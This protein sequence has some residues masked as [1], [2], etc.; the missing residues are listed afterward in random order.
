MLRACL[1]PFW[2]LVGC[3]QASVPISDGIAFE[4][5]EMSRP[6]GTLVQATSATA[7]PDGTGRAVDVRLSRPASNAPALEITAPRSTWDLKAQSAHF[8]GGVVVVRAGVE[9]RCAVLDVTY[10]SVDRLER[11]VASGSVEVRSGARRASGAT[12]VLTTATGEIVLTGSPTLTEGANT[13]S[14]STI[15]FLLDDE[16]VECQD[17]RLVVAG[18]AVAP[19]PK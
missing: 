19:I 5:V 17:C 2:V 16:R 6:D 9:L 7:S 12:A 14:G 10:A 4:Q 18:D 11:A 13:M 3:Q 15:R 1:A 8:E